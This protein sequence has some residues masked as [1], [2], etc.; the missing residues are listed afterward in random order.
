[1]SLMASETVFSTFELLEMILLQLD[2][3]TILTAA[4][5]T[6]RSWYGL[7]RCSLSLQRAL[8]FMPDESNSQGAKSIGIY[9]PLLAAAFPSFFPESRVSSSE[10]VLFSLSTLDMIKSPRRKS[11]FTRKEA[12]WRRML[13]QQPPILEF[14]FIRIRRSMRSQSYIQREIR[15]STITFVIFPFSPFFSFSNSPYSTLNKYLNQ[16]NRHRALCPIGIR[17]EALFDSLLFSTEL[18]LKNSASTQL[19]WTEYS[20]IPVPRVR[21]NLQLNRGFE[22]MI[23][24]YSLVIYA[25]HVIKCAKRDIESKTEEELLRDEILTS[26]ETSRGGDVSSFE[27][28]DIKESIL[29]D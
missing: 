10:D 23:T 25:R 24:R 28:V 13:I 9:N 1:M 20:Q 26:Y 15:V 2:L 21:Q 27:E 8:F 6:C 22:R 11:A 16:P 4:Q 12:S 18:S 19:F 3:R 17:M 7:I 5:L 14:A 29:L